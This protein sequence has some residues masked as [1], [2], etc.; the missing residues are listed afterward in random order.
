MLVIVQTYPAHFYQ[1][2]CCLRSVRSTMAGSEVLV[3]IDDHSTLCWPDYVRNCHDTY[4][5][6]VSDIMLAS[7]IS[8]MQLLRDD[9]WLRQQTMKLLL[10]T[11]I[12][13]D[14]WLFLDGDVTLLGPPPLDLVP[15]SRVRYAGVP[16]T[17]RDPLPGETSSQTL[18]YINHMLGADFEGFWDHED[19]GLLITA[20]HPPVRTMRRDLLQGL[21]QHVETRFHDPLVMI[22]RNLARNTRMAAS[23][24]DLMEFFRQRIWGEPAAWHW[25]QSFCETTWSSDRELGLQW[26]RDRSVDIDPEIWAILPDRKYF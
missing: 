19:S 13:L 12:D 8:D 22:H 2:L 24:W 21:R 1:T 23:E 16:L 4:Q 3:V 18:F 25:D 9:P 26:F 6:Y 20:S 11:V 17:E 10:D 5:G 7:R 14:Q 15:A